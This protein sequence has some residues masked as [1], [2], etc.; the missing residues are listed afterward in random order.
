MKKLL[1]KLG[2]FLVNRYAGHFSD[3]VLPAWTGCKCHIEKR[4]C[5]LHSPREFEYPANLTDEIDRDYFKQ[6]IEY[7]RQIPAPEFP[8]ARTHVRISH[9]WNFVMSADLDHVS[10]K[11][12][13]EFLALIEESPAIQ[14]TRG[15][16][17]FDFK[18]K[19][20]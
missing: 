8:K 5:L 6:W 13:K 9:D 10:H 4:A 14:V 16:N 17:H 1:F 11:N 18:R 3:T 15:W 20:A 2:R 7:V 12:L 19:K